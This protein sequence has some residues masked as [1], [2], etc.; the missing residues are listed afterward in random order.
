MAVDML[1]YKIKDVILVPSA[2]Y[3]DVPQADFHPRISYMVFIIIV[4]ISFVVHLNSEPETLALERIL[5]IKRLDNFQGSCP[6]IIPNHCKLICAIS[7]A[8][9]YL[10]R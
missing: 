9:E 10:L 6:I 8:L 7:T 5:V 2:T 4:V 1:G 3:V